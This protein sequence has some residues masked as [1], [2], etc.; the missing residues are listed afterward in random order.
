MDLV[1]WLA[2]WGILKIYGVGGKL[3]NSIKSFYKN[4]SACVKISGETKEHF[5]IKVGLRQ[6][7]VMSLWLFN[8]YMD[9]V[10]REMKRGQSWG[11][12]SKNVCR[13]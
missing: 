12:W 7:C 2:L 1:D 5:E 13:Q 11:S 6:G 3:L 4:I 10:I 8:I 9:G